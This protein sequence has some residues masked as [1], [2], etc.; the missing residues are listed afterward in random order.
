MKVLDYVNVPKQIREYK[1]RKVQKEAQKRKEDL[2]MLF[3][4]LKN[5]LNHVDST[6]VN[7]H[8]KKQFWSKFIKDG[9][10][11]QAIINQMLVKINGKG[12]VD[13]NAYWRKYKKVK[14]LVKTKDK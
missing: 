7:R 5:L 6:L 2:I 8:A 11:R 13:E 10:I 1:E 4:Q 12:I 14:P 3:R 9:K